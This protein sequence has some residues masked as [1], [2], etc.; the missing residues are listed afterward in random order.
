MR[1]RS[2]AG[3]MAAVLLAALALAGCTPEPPAGVDRLLT[4]DWAKPAQVEGYVPEAGI[5][6]ASRP[7]HYPNR[8]SVLDEIACTANHYGEVVHVG[9]F[10]TDARPGPAQLAAAYT[11]CD[12]K[13]KGYLGRF[14]WEART[15]LY[16]TVP[17]EAAW[18]GGARW[19]RCDVVEVFDASKDGVWL[20]RQGRL[21]EGIPAALLVGCVSA[22]KKGRT[23]TEM[24]EVACTAAHNAEWVGAFRASATTAYPASDR[25]WGVLHRQCRT[26]V[27]KFVGVGSSQAGR[28]ATI[29]STS[30]SASW[31][32]GDRRVRCAIWFDTKTM[33]KSARGTKG[34][35]LPNF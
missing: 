31:K 28:F 26:L 15:Q 18:A 22:K 2:T 1:G 25:Q 17:T 35:G 13:S 8:A 14:W 34:R 10:T 23:I 27:A 6:I 29:A 21:K 30:G 32:A 12:A 4:D 11:E 33:K 9:A 16:V 7:G 5:C 20:G 3:V 24:P 19:F